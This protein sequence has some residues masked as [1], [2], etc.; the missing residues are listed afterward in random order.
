LIQISPYLEHWLLDRAKQMKIKPADFK[1]PDD[2]KKLHELTHL[3][4]KQHF[5]EFLLKLIS[6]DTEMQT[7]SLWIEEFLVDKNTGTGL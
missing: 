3:E 5:K 7:L 1:L 2:P 6:V 4:K